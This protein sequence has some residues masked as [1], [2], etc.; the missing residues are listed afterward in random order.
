MTQVTWKPVPDA[1]DY[2]AAQDYLELLFKPE[3]VEIIVH[4]LKH[5]AVVQKKAKDIIRASG[6]P[7]LTAE[8]AHVAKNLKKVH[9]GEALSPILLVGGDNGQPLVIADGY[10][11][12]SAVYVL[13]EDAEVPCKLV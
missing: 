8:N 3:S 4:A 6:L 12:A 11:R 10:H 2:P 1:H 13:D 9:A 5:A 7:Y